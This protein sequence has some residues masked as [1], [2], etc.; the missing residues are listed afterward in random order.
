MLLPPSAVPMVKSVGSM[1]QV[2]LRP[3]PV[4]CV[5]MRALSATVT[6]AA[7]VSMK[8]PLPPSGAEAS[9]VPSTWVRPTAMSPSS[10]M[11]P[12]RCCTVRA[13]LMPLW[14]TTA[15]ASASSALASMRMA[16]PSALIWPA[17]STNACSAPRSMR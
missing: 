15:L 1:S 12:S 14:L 10:T 13:W 7:L 3:V 8:P 9:S 4:A 6:V 17:C 16:P 2:P 11:R 5:V